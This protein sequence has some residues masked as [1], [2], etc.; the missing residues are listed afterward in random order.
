MDVHIEEVVASV[1]AVDSNSILKPAVLA[2][3]VEA[4]LA[5]RDQIDDRRAQRETE[6]AIGPSIRTT[7]GPR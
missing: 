1:T 3:I 6:R 2:T 7:G 5:A 4:V